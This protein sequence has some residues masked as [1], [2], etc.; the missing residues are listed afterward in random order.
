MMRTIRPFIVTDDRRPR[1]LTWL[2]V[3]AGI[4]KSSPTHGGV[5]MGGAGMD[6]GFA[7][8][9]EIGRAVIGIQPWACRGER[10]GSNEHVNPPRV[11]RGSDVIHIGDSGYR[12]RKETL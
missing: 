5:V 1:D 6:M 10:C 7:L 2:I 4:G 11:P 8:V 9:Y 12:F 3:K